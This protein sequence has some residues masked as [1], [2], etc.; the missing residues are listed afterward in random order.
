MSKD[1]TW[2]PL[3]AMET[4]VIVNAGTEAPFSGRWLRHDGEGTYTCARCAAPLYNSGSKF[5][6]GCG[7]PSFDDTLPG[8][9]T[10]LA[11]PDGRRTEIRCARCDGHLGHVFRG[12]Q[13]T[14]KNTRHCVNSISIDFEDGPRAQA[15]FAGGCFWGVEYLMAA[16]PG[17]TA[18][19]SGY[20]GGQT[21]NPTYREVCSG[22]TGHAEA[23]RVTY[24]PTQVSFTD[25]AQLCFEI[26]DPTELN[27]QG[28]DIG[29]QYRSAVYCADAE[30]TRIV[31][32]LIAQLQ[33]QG[34]PVVTEVEPAKAFWPAES[35]H[36]DYYEKTGKQP[37]CHRRVKRFA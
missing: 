15:F 28:P 17:V 10:E 11:D 18:A 7:W 23:V 2:K 4:H 33:S 26:H 31:E 35:G 32:E 21:D 24:D 29:T 1:G 5:E 9:I 12:E 8:A 37:Y 30:Q 19:D 3:S 22:R 27:R 13:M 34:L 6:S 20:M 25:L 14:F 16:V 36:Q